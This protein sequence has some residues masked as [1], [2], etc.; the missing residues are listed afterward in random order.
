MT[1]ITIISEKDI[2][3]L[4]NNGIV[5]IKATDYKQLIMSEERYKQYINS[6]FKEAVETI[7]YSE[8]GVLI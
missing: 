5:E 4:A 7:K 8:D 3:I 1:K 6:D 2:E